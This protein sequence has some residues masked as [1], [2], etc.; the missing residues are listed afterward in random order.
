L[1]PRSCSLLNL[2]PLLGIALGLAMDAFSVAIATAIVLGEVSGRQTFRLVFHFGLFQFLMPIVGWL[3]GGRVSEYTSTY[4]PWIAFALLA[5]VGGHMIW[6]SLCSDEQCRR[7]DPTR[8][9]SLVLLS[10]ATSLDALA[11]GFS[12]AL[13]DISAWFPSIVIGLVASGMTFLGLRLGKRVGELMGRRMEM[14]GGLVL[15]TIGFRIL[16]DRVAG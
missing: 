6:Q 3:V 7:G 8:G 13:L 15:L 9:A 12:L 1:G 14:V 2:L 5:Y 16:F 10:I 4:G 11:V